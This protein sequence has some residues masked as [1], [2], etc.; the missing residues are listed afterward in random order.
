MTKIYKNVFRNS[1]V[2]LIGT[3]IFGLSVSNISLNWF[4]DD[5]SSDISVDG[6]VHGSY[7]ESGDGS[8][9]KPFEIARPIQLYYLSWLQEMGYFNEAVLNTNTGEYEL[10]QQYHFYL[11][12]DI[13]MDVQ[14][15]ATY[16]LPPIGTMEYPFVG[17][18]D[19][20]GHVIKDLKISNDVSEYTNDPRY[21]TGGSESYETLGLFGVLGTT[22]S[23]NIVT[24]STIDNAGNI[25]KLQT[26]GDDVLVSYTTSSN[27]VQNIY[28]DNV[29]IIASTDS[30]H[31]LA[32]A[33]AGYSNATV[34]NIGI[35]GATLTFANGTSSVGNI[36]T[37]NLSDYTSFG[38]VT[39]NHKRDVKIVNEEVYQ[40]KATAKNYVSNSSGTA[41]GGS[42]DM[43]NLLK[44]TFKSRYMAGNMNE[45][46]IPQYPKQETYVYDEDE[47]ID[48]SVIYDNK[49]FDCLGDNRT[50]PRH[51]G[52]VYYSS[53]TTAVD[54][55]SGNYD[56]N[57]NIGSYY[58]TD[59][60]N[61]SRHKAYVGG[62]SNISQDTAK[63]VYRTFFSGT[64][65]D[66]YYVRS[67]SSTGNNFIGINSSGNIT[68]DN[69]QQNAVKWHFSNGK[70][71]AKTTTSQSIIAHETLYYLNCNKGDFSIGSTSNTTWALNNGVFSI[72]SQTETGY[73]IRD[74]NSHYLS[75]NGNSTPTTESNANN[76]TIWNIAN[77]GNS[78]SGKIST[79]YNGST[80]Y[81]RSSGT[82]TSST[83]QVNTTNSNNTI[84]RT[85]N[86]S[87]DTYLAIS[88]GRYY[89]TIT[90]NNG[91]SISRSSNL[92]STNNLH[93]EYAEKVYEYGTVLTSEK[94]F[95][96]NS[97]S[98][99][100][101][102][103]PGYIPLSVNGDV[104][105]IPW[106]F[107]NDFKYETYNEQNQP[108]RQ[109][110][111]ID[112]FYTS[113]LNT[114]YIVGGYYDGTNGGEAANPPSTEYIGDV[115]IS[116][117]DINSIAGSWTSSG[118]FGTIYTINDSS[119][120]G[121]SEG[122]LVT[123]N[124]STASNLNFVKFSEAYQNL[125]NTL[126]NSGSNVSGIH[127]MDSN[128][129][130]DKIITAPKALINDK[131]KTNFEMPEDS[132]DFTLK[133]K[134]YINFFAGNYH[135]DNNSF[136]ALH[137]IKRDNNDKIIEMPKIKYIFINRENTE[138]RDIYL[139]ENG[140]WSDNYNSTSQNLSNDE[141]R[142]GKSSFKVD[143]EYYD[144]AFD[145]RWIGI[146]KNLIKTKGNYIYYFEIPVN[147]GEY[148][149]GSCEGG[150]GGYLIYLDISAASHNIQ[151]KTVNELFTI[152]TISGEIPYGTQYISSY[153]DAEI[154]YNEKGEEIK[155]AIVRTDINNIND[156]D[157]YY[158]S[159]SDSANGNYTINRNNNGFTVQGDSAITSNYVTDGVNLNG[160]PTSLG[161][162]S[163]RIR[164]IIDY[165]YNTV[166]HVYVK[167][168]TIIVIE[169]EGSSAHNYATTTIEYNKT[170]FNASLTLL[171]KYSYDWIGDGPT[172]HYG[173]YLHLSTGTGGIELT[174]LNPSNND[175]WLTVEY[176]APN[177]S[178]GCGLNTTRMTDTLIS[179]SVNNGD[180]FPKLKI[181]T[182]SVPSTYSPDKWYDFG[183]ANGG[184]TNNE[185]SVT[186]NVIGSFNY[187]LQ[188]NQE[189][190]DNFTYSGYDSLQALTNG[191]Y[192]KT[193]TPITIT[194]GQY[195]YE[196]IL[197]GLD[198]TTDKPI[199][200]IDYDVDNGTY[201]T[202]RLVIHYADGTTETRVLEPNP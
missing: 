152:D 190:E 148:A 120:N 170:G 13:D 183:K 11:S 6:N 21:R 94:P 163:K 22:E 182:T 60:G 171:A 128:I 196:F 110:L 118:G 102:G 31:A 95:I 98:I 140:E 20:K 112:Q 3:C 86:N 81:L 195:T 40:P 199:V 1:L 184:Y 84:Y 138:K 61:D 117:Y 96:I 155:D 164:R 45:G 168:T 135:N 26:N 82:S 131:P 189:I 37:T 89:F 97:A 158:G 4:S 186:P 77:F 178:L 63:T 18:F 147:K 90:Y 52:K 137:E 123:F 39:A 142:N 38:F 173:Y 154:S 202:I 16:I 153:A 201:G 192:A 68:I 49:H 108:I 57:K 15:E 127:F 67:S 180:G 177:I 56:T 54:A 78:R 71:Y 65:E 42:V 28:L 91:W 161:R 46:R 5:T 24:C 47:L 166:T 145:T 12:K 144:F 50:T 32:G 107:E 179:E 150:C 191:E 188:G 130:M 62:F 141:I 119:Y 149:L 80:Y 25:S 193:E 14:D 136:F 9:S 30:E 175:F 106:D 151:R 134:G 55:Y 58:F 23:S 70:L 92:P 121:N 129:G 41:W 79:T 66:C 198:V 17:S 133:E 7:F 194:N 48:Y 83:L 116:E 27:Y 165:D 8:V 124:T 74:N 174:F 10:K 167:Q 33:V 34:S 157:S 93:L 105:S 181:Y 88:A 64:E 159:I 172:F 87:L 2:T 104:D 103:Q 35:K 72:P 176:L 146:N 43:L 156:L 111:T 19:G 162:T 160:N 113:S 85:N 122:S 69:S 187:I 114:G 29:T 197:S 143:G 125:N 115:R 200:S 132:I 101:S 99:E 126:S 169:G 53:D 75:F 76:A 73:K 109:D 44:R 36:G 100:G 59:M 185:A 139:Y 51:N